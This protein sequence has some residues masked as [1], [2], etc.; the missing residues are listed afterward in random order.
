MGRFL[1]LRWLLVGLGVAWSGL[2]WATEDLHLLFMASSGTQRSALSVAL[3]GFERENP[4]IKV[5]QHVYAQEE[6]KRDFEQRI[7][8]KPI[9]VAFWFAGERLRQLAQKSLIKPLDSG[10]AA[11]PEMAQFTRSSLTSTRIGDKTY[12]LPLSYYAWGFFYS[13]SLFRDMHLAPPK[14]WAD[15]LTVCA[16]LKSRGVT[17]TAVG[18][19]AGWPAAAWFDYLD[20]RMNGLGF[21]QKL[22]RGEISFTDQR[23]RAVFNQWQQLLKSGYFLPEA[24]ALD[25]DG[26][27]P[28]LYRR[29]VAM[30]LMGG[31][32]A[33][34]FPAGTLGG[35]DVESDIG[36]FAF[37][38]INPNMKQYEDAPLDVFVQ[39][40][41]GQNPGAAAK[42]LKYIASNRALNQ[43]NESIRQ[44]SPRKDAPP[45]TD[46]FLGAGRSILE[47]AD[48]IAFFFDR[49]ARESLIAP[50]FEAFRD[51]L[52]PPFDVD[53]AIAHMG[54]GARP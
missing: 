45:T 50:G 34:K 6:Y 25:W 46:P 2:A 54:Q 4:D 14:S 29:Q 20:L 38:V 35:R 49:D 53:A 33:A 44:L 7:S 48:G 12:G 19:K 40:A 17:P 26:V 22:L 31:F 30:V 23:V 10:F 16:T 18:A 41:S 3:E 28:Y 43:Y 27:L 36:F 8:S 32:A 21:H 37:P 5:I 39:P 1:V 51:F 47:N 13:K 24:M 42:L 52:Q 15:F 11:G 9:D